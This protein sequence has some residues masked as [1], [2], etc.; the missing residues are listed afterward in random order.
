LGTFHGYNATILAYGQTGSGKT[1]TMGTGCTIGMPFDQVGIVP[2][3]FKFIF[4]E[5]D[6]RKAQSEYSSFRISISFL[7]IYNEEIHD[8]LDPASMVRDKITGKPGKEVSIREE[9]NGNISVRGL[10]DQEV[11][12]ED[13]CSHWLNLGINHRQTSATLMNEGSSRSHA[14][15]T[16]TIEQK[17]VKEVETPE[18]EEKKEDGPATVTEEISAKFHFVDLAGSERIKKT[19]ASGKLMKEGISINKGL[20]NLGLVISA[21]T[22]ESGGSSHIPYRDSKVTRILQDSLGGNSRTT[23][24][25]CV[26]PAESNYEETM[27]TIKYAS[28]ARN[29]KNKPIVNRD[30]NSMLIE[31]LRG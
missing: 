5:V 29:I 20:L 7:E 2:R 23:M 4:D 22:K 6:M 12:K 10:K 9:K 28:R 13:E 17:I 21:L 24:I 30:P 18:G 27:G 1:H 3:V 16:I 25:A 19:G 11:S 31:S 14:I 26:S 15:F 8:L